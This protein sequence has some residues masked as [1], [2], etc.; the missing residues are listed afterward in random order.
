MSGKRSAIRTT[1][2]TDFKGVDFSTDASLVSPSRSPWAVN[3]LADTGGMPEKRPGWRV[4]QE[5][6]APVNGIWTLE[7]DDVTHYVVHGGTKLYHWT[8]ETEAVQLL[9]GLTDGKSTAGIMGGKLYILT[10]GE[11][12]VYDGTDAE[13]VVGYV[14]TTIIGRAPTGGGVV[15]EDINLVSDSQKNEFI[16]D[17]TSTVYVLSSMGLDSVDK[18]VFRG[19]EMTSG[20]TADLQNGTV[21]FATAPPAPV[22]GQE[23]ELVITFSKAVEGYRDRIAKCTILTTYGVGTDDRMIFAGNP[24][25]PNQDWTSGL[26]DPTYVP[27]LSYSVV[28]GEQTAIMGYARVGSY[29]AI[30]KSDNGQ[31]TTVYMRSGSLSDAGEATFPVSQS[32]SGV[33]A[34]AKRCFGN[35]SGEN[36]FLSRNG[37]YALTSNYL[38]AERIVMNRSFFVDRLLTGEADLQDAVSCC[39]NGM[40]LVAVNGHVYLLDGKQDKAYKPKSNGEYVYECYYWEGIPS[41]ALHCH[42]KDNIEEVLMGSQDGR[43]CKLNTDVETMERYSDDGEAIPCVWATVSD[44]DG[45]PMVYKTMI[46]KGNAATI[47]P[48]TRSSAKICFRTDRDAVDYQVAYGTMDIFDWEDIDFSRFTFNANDGPQEILFNAKVKKYKRLQILIRNDGLNEGFGIFA[49]SKH[50]VTGNFAK[51]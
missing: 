37:V 15:F 22:A 33:G 13:E 12:L 23:G 14:P 46:K 1:I 29:L 10:G 16:C 36:L 47:K 25:Y 35:I 17:G 19:E 8:G 34:V 3:L 6:E 24:E 26:Y 41:S 28:G 45:D 20:W 42:K 11:F 18:V 27:D 44:D 43:V 50:F 4:L 40:F 32:V 5:V 51:R 2:Y 7:K 21:T 31:E 39:W 30:V 38:T 49:I 9:S 48:F